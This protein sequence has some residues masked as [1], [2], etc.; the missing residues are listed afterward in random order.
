MKIAVRKLFKMANE[1]ISISNS[2]S[3]QPV[4]H[5]TTDAS[6]ITQSNIQYTVIELFNTI[7]FY[8]VKF[9]VKNFI[10]TERQL[11]HII[12]MTPNTFNCQNEPRFFPDYCS[13][14]NSN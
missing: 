8:L 11:Y 10:T 14:K 3:N 13:M 2:V 4:V 1:I 7:Q 6:N 5:V 12:S 9:N